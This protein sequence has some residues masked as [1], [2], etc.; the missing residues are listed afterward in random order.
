MADLNAADSTQVGENTGTPI[1]T[2]SMF[3]FFCVSVTNEG[4]RN[5]VRS[6]QIAFAP[7]EM[8]PICTAHSR[9]FTIVIF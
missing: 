2:V 8:A 4:W 6:E 9:V 1:T 3:L 5:D 7:T